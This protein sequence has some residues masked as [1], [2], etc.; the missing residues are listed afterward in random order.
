MRSSV[1]MSAETLVTLPS[2]TGV[3]RWSKAEKCSIA[4]WPAWTWSI[5]A[6]SIWARTMRSTSCGTM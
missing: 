3:V 5:F 6:A 2:I 1:K 4:V